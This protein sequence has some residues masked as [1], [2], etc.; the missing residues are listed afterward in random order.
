MV[1][2]LLKGRKLTLPNPNQA[3]WARSSLRH[4]KELR[5][6]LAKPRNHVETI[7]LGGASCYDPPHF[8]RLSYPSLSTP[9]VTSFDLKPA[10]KPSVIFPSAMPP[11]HMGKAPLLLNPPSLLPLEDLPPRPEWTRP[12]TPEQTRPA[13]PQWTSPSQVVMT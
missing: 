13:M 7:P 3:K 8:S 10:T 5:A 12:A 2:N 9:E 11:E 4:H 1:T 6:Q